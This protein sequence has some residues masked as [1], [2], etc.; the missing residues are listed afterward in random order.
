MCIY[1]INEIFM[2]LPTMYV[3]FLDRSTFFEQIQTVVCVTGPL[4]DT[5]FFGREYIYVCME[6]GECHVHYVCTVS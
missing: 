5:Y 2:E 6:Y 1:N 4:V 3:S